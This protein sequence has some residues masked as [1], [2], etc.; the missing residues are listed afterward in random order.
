MVL[1]QF[2]RALKDSFKKT[3]GFP[4]FKKKVRLND[5]YVPAKMAIRKGV[6][7]CAPKSGSEMGKTQN[8]EGKPNQLQFSQDG[9]KW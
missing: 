9:N 8:Y 6:C 4:T 2:D 3:K 7:I 5:S 1:R